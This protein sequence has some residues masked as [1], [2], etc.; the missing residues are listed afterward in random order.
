MLEAVAVL[1][2]EEDAPPL[3]HQRR[4]VGAP[5]VEGPPTVQLKENPLQEQVR[6]RPL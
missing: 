5:P 2:E 3:L 4:P 1:R 6:P